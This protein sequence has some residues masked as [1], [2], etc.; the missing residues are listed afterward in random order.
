MQSDG[1]RMRPDQAGNVRDSARREVTYSR[2]MKQ[3]GNLLMRKTADGFAVA[4]TNP[5][6]F[7][8]ECHSARQPTSPSSNHLLVFSLLSLSH[9]C[10]SSENRCVIISHI[11]QPGRPNVLSP[12]DVLRLTLSC[13]P[14]K[15]LL[16]IRRGTG[17]ILFFVI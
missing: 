6:I 10:R 3:E 17:T 4:W 8:S 7:T 11:I 13:S 14:S 1:E 9:G 5:H 15:S 2:A 12:G 16:P